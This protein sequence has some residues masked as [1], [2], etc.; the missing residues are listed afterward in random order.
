MFLKSGRRYETEE[1]LKV[2]FDFIRSM[3]RNGGRWM[4]I[5]YLCPENEQALFSATFREDLPEVW[6]F[7]QADPGM[8]L[9]DQS[10]YRLTNG[11][12]NGFDYLRASSDCFSKLST[13]LNH[14]AIDF[15]DSRS[16]CNLRLSSTTIAN[17]TKPSDLSQTFWASR[18]SGDHEMNFF[19]VD[20]NRTETW[21][22]LYF[23]LKH[24]LNDTSTTG[25]MRNRQRIWNGLE[26]ITPCM[27]S[28]LRQRPRLE[29]TARCREELV[30][31][32][33]EMTQ[34]TQG[35][36]GVPCTNPSEGIQ[37][38][39]SRYLNLRL[40]GLGNEEMRILVSRVYLDKRDYICGFRA[41]KPDGTENFRIGLIQPDAET[42]FSLR[43]SDQVVAVHVATTFGGIVGLAFR[44]KD[45]LGGVSWK[46]VGKVDKP[47]VHV[48]IKMLEPKNGP[49]ISGLLL[50][51]D[52]C[53]VVSIQLV[54]KLGDFAT[55]ETST[56]SRQ[57]V[58]HP[59]APQPDVA[60]VL[61]PTIDA[62]SPQPSFILNMDF[63]GPSGSLLP[64]LNRIVVFLD[65]SVNFSIRGLGFYY[66]DGTEREFGFREILHD[67]RE[68]SLAIEQSLSINGPAGERITGV[69]FLTVLIHR[70]HT[71]VFPYSLMIT[72]NFGRC[73]KT[74][75]KG[76]PLE[77]T[78]DDSSETHNL[79]SPHGETITG[80]L[81]PLY[82]SPSLCAVEFLGLAH[83]NS[84]DL[85]R[86]DS[87][88]ITFDYE[89]EEARSRIDPYSDW[90]IE[91][92]P[93]ST[94]RLNGVKRVGISNGR[95]GRSRLPHHVAGFCFEFWDGRSPV[96][97]GQ[98]FHEIDHLDLDEGD[99][100][101]SLTLWE[102]VEIDDDDGS[103]PH[104]G[105]KK[106]TGVRIEKSGAEPNAVEVHP[107][108]HGDMIEAC[109]AENH[110]E[111]LDGFIWSLYLESDR[112]DVVTKPAKLAKG[113][114][115]RES[116]EHEAVFA[117]SNKLF[118]RIQ[119]KEGSW[120]SVSQMT[121]FFNPRYKRLCGM[122][123]IYRDGQLKRAGYTEGAKATLT[124]DQ[125]EGV[126]GATWR[127]RRE[128]GGDE[129]SVDVE[130][131]VL[132][133]GDHCQ[134]CKTLWHMC[135]A[136]RRRMPQGVMECVG[137]FLDIQRGFKP[138]VVC[139]VFGP[140]YVKLAD[141]LRN[142]WK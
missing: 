103:T 11:R 51:L 141:E 115:S 106:F 85:L 53:K 20:H 70:E 26:N 135:E 68:R 139:H 60:T 1:L 134:V 130:E 19:P 121:A 10:P 127:P 90:P 25:H 7:L 52:A 112:V 136:R 81:A 105:N 47:D 92:A 13:E 30:S 5:S 71:V 67:S 74:T 37:V 62:A 2:L 21:R 15:L 39:G 45:E 91:R 8:I 55:I 78:E 17:L 94:V 16:F 46:L 54:E 102:E 9:T 96:Y 89:K 61:P 49:Y 77:Y 65:S 32:G 97:V 123:F 69:G 138:R 93:S 133:D 120:T 132:D 23:N 72:T 64:L 107:G 73:L 38:V 100:I 57:L 59:A 35:L 140:V 50:G 43:S 42:H 31:L 34:K 128:H 29:S 79:I 6:A 98:W 129:L 104:F 110:F 82:M 88:P 63:G 124:L 40:G 111:R 14:C 84:R 122:E 28:M 113:D 86:L 24:S 99:R 3:P 137:V 83:L 142:S 48:G 126:T 41:R 80:F 18:F 66:T 33:Y 76:R 58:W 118:W 27:I 36:K 75:N 101:T 44:I 12:T 114:L 22:N 4:W 108:S 116:I 87:P 131:H 56:P 117:D 109:Y 119:D 95:A 125:G